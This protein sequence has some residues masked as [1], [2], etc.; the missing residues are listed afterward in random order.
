M[1]GLGNNKYNQD[2]LDTAPDK[3]SPKRPT[4]MIGQHFSSVAKKWLIIV[5]TTP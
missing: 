5:I 1:I 2:Q 4:P 3:E